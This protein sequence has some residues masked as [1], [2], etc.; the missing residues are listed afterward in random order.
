MPKIKKLLFVGAYPP[1]YGEIS[2][3]HLYDLLP[4]LNKHGYGIVLLT[5][6][7]EGTTQ[8]SPAMKRIFIKTRNFYNNNKLK[9]FFTFIRFL[10]QEKKCL[11]RILLK[12]LLRQSLS[13]K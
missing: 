9:V 12:L 5:L 11:G 4:R 7:Q 10:G 6:D 3:S 8:E 1:P 2:S 13:M